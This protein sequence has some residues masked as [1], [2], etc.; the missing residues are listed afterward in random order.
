MILFISGP[1][2]AGEVMNISTGDH[3]DK[4][5]MVIDF[6]GDADFQAKIDNQILIIHLPKKTLATKP[7]LIPPFQSIKTNIVSDQFL[8]L[9]IPLSQPHK[10]KTAFV[11]AGKPHRLVID[12]EKGKPDNINHGTIMIEKSRIDTMRAIRKPIIVI[13]AGHGG[14]DSGAVGSGDI[15]EKDIVLSIAKIFAKQL[16]NSGRYTAK[17]TRNNDKFIS[18]YNRVD[19]AKDAK[20][21]LFI[22]IHADSLR[23]E[24][25]QGASVYTVSEKASDIETEKLVQRE[26]TKRDKTDNQN[27]PYYIHKILVNMAMEDTIKK[28]QTLA[29]TVITQLQKSNIQTITDPHRH[30]GFVVLKSPEIPSVLFETGFI[31]DKKQAQ[32]L[33]DPSYQK[34]ISRALLKSLDEYFRF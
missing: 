24:Q 30:G 8:K 1:L 34:Q 27:H 25:A 26:N 13:D 16:N 32:K 23:G 3:N 22:S 15:C 17:L 6:N 10:I 31:S 14:H 18:L 33:I 12:I 29:D 20:A 7:T 9:S 5:R 11:I 2:M 28:S 21:D 4:S 19:I